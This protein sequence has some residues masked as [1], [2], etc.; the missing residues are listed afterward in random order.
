[1]LSPTELLLVFLIVFV[2]FGANKLPKLGLGLGQAVRNFQGAL[3]GEKTEPENRKGET[4]SKP[5][6]D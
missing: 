3:K 5:K 1:M 2:L 6:Q 4:P